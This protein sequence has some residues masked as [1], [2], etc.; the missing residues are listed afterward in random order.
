MLSMSASWN[1][2]AALAS[3]LKMAYAPCRS[4]ISIYS[5]DAVKRLPNGGAELYE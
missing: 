4:S 5:I 1:R 3:S 2:S